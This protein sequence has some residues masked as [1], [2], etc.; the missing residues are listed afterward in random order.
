MSYIMRHSTPYANATRELSNKPRERAY[1]KGSHRYSVT[2]VKY[3]KYTERSFD[4]VRFYNQVRTD[5]EQNG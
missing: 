5:F 2:P 4:L 1:T 3:P